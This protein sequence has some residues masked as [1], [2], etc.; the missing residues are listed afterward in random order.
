M[1]NLF[2]PATVDEIKTRLGKLTPQS[3]RQWGKMAPAQAVAHC[4]GGMAWA[5]N[6]SV[7]PRMFL[8]RIVGGF[9]KPLVLKDDAPIRKNSPTIKSLIINDNRDLSAEREK[10]CNQ[11][12][13]FAAARHEGCTTHPH[14]FF[15]K[16]TPDEWA[17]LM[18]KHIDHH[19]RQFGA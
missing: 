11:I 6:D 18:Y 15:G 8:G 1:K 16:L 13:R 9:V 17:I 4:S 14:P 7:P 12:D 3:E 5:V 2:E 19:L 10:L